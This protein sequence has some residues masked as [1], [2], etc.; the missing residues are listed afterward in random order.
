[1]FEIPCEVLVSTSEFQHVAVVKRVDKKKLE[2]KPLLPRE[3]ENVVFTAC[4]NPQIPDFPARDAV[5]EC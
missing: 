5:S 2:K 1:M 4:Q 3:K